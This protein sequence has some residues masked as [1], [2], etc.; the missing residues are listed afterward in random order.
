MRGLT[1]RDRLVA[2]NATLRMID[3]VR[4]LIGNENEL[5]KIERLV[6]DREVADLEIVSALEEI[7]ARIEAV[8][9]SRMESA[10]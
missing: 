1:L 4:T 2:G 8:T 9:R 7:D 10:P 5:D 3:V 6:V